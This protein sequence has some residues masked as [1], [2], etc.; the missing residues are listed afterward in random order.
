MS[1][2]RFYLCSFCRFDFI[3]VD[4]NLAHFVDSPPH[5][6][7]D[8]P[9]AAVRRHRRHRRRILPAR[10]GPSDLLQVGQR[11]YCHMVAR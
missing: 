11:Q 5:S 7:Q 8:A 1:F 10:P 6:D 2:S 4:F 9:S 3:F